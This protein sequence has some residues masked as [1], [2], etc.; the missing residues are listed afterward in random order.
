MGDKDI[1]HQPEFD[2]KQDSSF[3]AFFRS[4]PKDDDALVRFFDRRTFYS[5]HGDA[6]HLVA[7]DYF[8]TSTVI[9]YLGGSGGGGNAPHA[10][11]ATAAAAA[12]GLASTAMSTNMFEQIVRDLLLNRNMRVELYAPSSGSGSGW[13][14]IRRGSPGNLQQFEDIFLSEVGDPQADSAIAM[15]IKLN[16]ANGV[17]ICFAETT[18]RVIGVCEFVD[19]EKFGNL[20][21]LLIQTGV[22]E[23][24]IEAS[25]SSSH[26]HHHS[27]GRS[28]S[29]ASADRTLRDIFTQ[30]GIVVT[31]RLRKDFSGPSAHIEQ[32]LSRLLFSNSNNS[33]STTHAMGI[34]AELPL[35]TD[36]CSALIKYLDLLSDETSHGAFSFSRFFLDQY[37]RLDA[38]VV[39][40][41]NI[42]GSQNNSLFSLLNKHC[43]N[44]MGSRKLMQWLRQPLLD[45]EEITKRQDLVQALV[46]DSVLRQSLSEEHLRRIHDV[47]HLIKKLQRRRATLEDCIKVYQLVMRVPMVSTA[48]DTNDRTREWPG[49][50]LLSQCVEDSKPLATMIETTV[51]V[52]EQEL[53]ILPEFD[54][55]LQEIKERRDLVARNMDAYY[56]QHFDVKRTGINIKLD[57]HSTYGHV[58]RVS[59]KDERNIRDD[60]DKIV[61]D[62]RKDGV[63]F[64]TSKLKRMS[65]EHAELTLQYQQTQTALVEKVVEVVATYIPVMSQ[66]GSVLSEL[67]VLCAL[68]TAAVQ[69]PH[70]GYVR[71]RIQA[72]A[73]GSASSPE[74]QQQQHVLELY[75]CRH[76]CLE[77]QEGVEFIANDCR[78]EKGSS[79]FTIITGPNCGGKSTYSR[80]VGLCV[81][82]AHIG[83]FIP[84]SNG[85]GSEGRQS[86]VPV[87]DSIMARVGASDSQSRGVS[88]FMAE[89]LETA[90]I[91]Q[92]ATRQSLVI[93]DEL[94]RG[95]S[96]YDG[97]G[98][99]AAISEHIARDIQCFCLF[100]TH[101]HELTLLAELVPGVSNCHVTAVSSEDKKKLTFLY[102]VRPG[103]C[104]QSFGIQVAEM[105]GFPEEV[106]AMAK[107]KATLLEATNSATISGSDDDMDGGGN[108][109]QEGSGG[110]SSSRKRRRLLALVAPSGRHSAAALQQE[111]ALPSAV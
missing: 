31:E 33:T 70:G 98:L 72:S 90:S 110:S 18:Q 108:G 57:V 1:H 47:D 109:R 87:V 42:F 59:R 88:T 13:K 40:A 69:A 68:A 51:S 82:M 103:P 12:A 16:G 5:V 99:A 25:T 46:E 105:V 50:V 45:V 67:D 104:D 74:Q 107:E 9:K 76:P 36:A 38:A 11:P 39:K 14:C 60:A 62:T 96:T 83:S 28:T 102:E 54:E 20:H 85:G 81:L 77:V 65:A 43:R 3:I 34:L 37:M 66:M 86:T 101:F 19:N 7:G 27:S 91:L 44:N 32:D 58:L 80:S 73:L 95:T 26:H 29:S 41:L 78:M 111:R 17:G 23:V 35:A 71:P 48:L 55:T 2:S 79:H 24:L 84:C 106:I 56:H 4:L 6:A 63:L 8:K 92:S 89:M 52:N 49:A 64:T 97:F 93:I 15:A 30:C 75:G 53:M 61:L 21:S 22:K 94:G 100:A 10:S